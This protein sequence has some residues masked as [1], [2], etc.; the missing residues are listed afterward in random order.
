MPG[1]AP[2]VTEHGFTLPTTEDFSQRSGSIL[3]FNSFTMEKVSPSFLTFIPL[4]LL[5]TTYHTL[6]VLP[7]LFLSHY[8][9][10]I[11]YLHPS[12]NFYSSHNQA[13]LFNVLCLL[14]S[15]SLKSFGILSKCCMIEFY[16]KPKLKAD[17]T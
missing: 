6:L 17:M 2:A 3:H 13:M 5:F 8:R 14:C 11:F 15:A 16:L 7:S 10:F 1:L 9:V 4:L 12:I